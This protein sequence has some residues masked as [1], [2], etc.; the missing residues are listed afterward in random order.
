MVAC[1]SKR[2]GPGSC[3]SL[4]AP[5]RQTEV[6]CR[7]RHDDSA[8]YL[9]AIIADLFALA[10]KHERGAGGGSQMGWGHLLK[11]P[12]CRLHP[13]RSWPQSELG[14]LQPLPKSESAGMAVW[15]ARQGP[16]L[17][18]LARPSSLCHLPRQ[19]PQGRYARC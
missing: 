11:P 8:R 2:A 18:G 12:P 17:T 3:V 4:S 9:E 5:A 16:G 19:Q 13:M 6:V 10:V 14:G 15:P 1:G 7:G